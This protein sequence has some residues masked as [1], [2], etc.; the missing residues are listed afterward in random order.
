MNELLDKLPENYYNEFSYWLKITTVLKSLNKFE[1]WDAFSKMSKKYNK[2]N[3]SN[4]WNSCKN[5]LNINYLIH[6]LNNE[7]NLKVDEIQYYKEY[8][9]MQNCSANL[10]FNSKYVSNNFSYEMF[11]NNNSIVIE[12][13]TG[14]GKTTATAQRIAEYLITDDKIRVLSIV[15]KISL[16]S[17]H[18]KSF[19]DEGIILRNYQNKSDKLR[20]S[21]LVI[22][23]NSLRMLSYLTEKEL[24]NY[25][26]Y[27]D[28]INSFLEG[29]THNN[30]LDGQI[31]II[32]V[33]LLRLVKYCNKI[34]V[35]DA[36]ISENVFIFLQNRLT[37][38]FIKNEFKKFD[39]VKAY[40][41]HNETEYLDL[42][43]AHIRDKKYFL[44]ACDSN[45]IITKLFI[46]LKKDNNPDEFILITADTE[47]KIKNAS[48]QFL[49]KFVFYS[50]S[51]VYGIDFSIEKKQDAFLYITGKSILPSGF[52]QQVCRT[53]NLNNLYYYCDVNSR[54]PKFETLTETKTYYSN[55]ENM[56]SQLIECCTTSD[57]LDELKVSRNTFFKLFCY[58]EFVRDIYSTNKLI[59]FE[60]ILINNKF[61][62]FELGTKAK[63]NKELKC[64]MQ[65]NKVENLDNL[66]NDWVL[67]NIENK[68]FEANCNK[69][70]ISN[71]LKAKFKDEIIDRTNHENFIKLFR[72]DD[73]IKFKLA[74]LGIDTYYLKVHHDA[75]FKVFLVRKIEK[76]F[77]I[78][79]LN[80]NFNVDIDEKINFENS[81]YNVIKY[82]FVTKKDIPIN[83]KML[84]EL[85]VMMLKNITGVKFID[86]KRKKSNNV[87]SYEYNLINDVIGY[88]SSLFKLSSHDKAEFCPDVS[89]FLSFK[90]VKLF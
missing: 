2:M 56:N 3:N 13:D 31:K 87:L 8:Y 49:N 29:L 73:F 14:T 47:F 43:K 26:I 36:L 53:R 85:Y 16:A 79:F 40:N 65:I 19:K 82:T 32:M 30:L 48:E 70:N 12:S 50:P 20:N 58:N 37:V 72:S 57:E 80:V 88:H 54:M 27:I 7:L 63:I 23:V 5:I 64:K 61:K 81:L 1:I 69:L 9:P 71:N 67:N 83:K 33:I 17:Q 25:I 39:G 44:F 78:D 75:Y 76:L 22:C 38:F 59:H 6:I 18:I 4:I 60:N 35:S 68:T 90:K 66:F 21:N 74:E 10:I 15:N 86:M 11:M 34:I 28:E 41:M 89:K 45:D 46:E 55:I 77:N 62:I 24:H 52:Y 84:K 42:I 51:I